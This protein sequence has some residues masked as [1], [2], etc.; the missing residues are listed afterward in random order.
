VFFVFSHPLSS[1]NKFW[2]SLAMNRRS[3]VSRQHYQ[4]AYFTLWR[5][6]SCLIFIYHSLNNL[7]NF[8]ACNYLVSDFENIANS[9]TKK[10]HSEILL[11]VL[12]IFLQ[13]RL[14]VRE[15][16]FRKTRNTNI[17]CVEK[18]KVWFTLVIYLSL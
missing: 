10:M 8:T 16:L 6:H 17:I 11:M 3:M 18:T 14:P 12:L 5:K 1:D 15:R 9:T 7:H 4:K 2:R 13:C